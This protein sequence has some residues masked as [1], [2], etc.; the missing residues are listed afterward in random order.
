MNPPQVF[1]LLSQTEPFFTV[2]SSRKYRVKR[3]HDEDRLRFWREGR[4]FVDAML[5]AVAVDRFSS[6]LDYGCG[7]GRLLRCMVPHATEAHGVD[8]S[9][10]LLEKAAQEC[11][12]ATLHHYDQWAVSPPF[13]EFS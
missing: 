12:G 8:I 5:S 3:M 13:V 7:I 1:Q 9:P 2:S 6:V 11:P 10:R 4:Q